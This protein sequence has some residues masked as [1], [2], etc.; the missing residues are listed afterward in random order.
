MI[1]H[2]D[3]GD[4]LKEGFTWLMVP[5]RQESVMPGQ[6]GKQGAGMAAGAEAK[7]S[8]LEPLKGRKESK[9]EMETLN[10]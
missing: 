4:L 6:H 10:S 2:Q 7:G 8:H 5:E 1:K 9:L 3:Q